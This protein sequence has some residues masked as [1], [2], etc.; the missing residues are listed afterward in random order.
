MVALASEYV[1]HAGWVLGRLEQ[2]EPSLVAVLEPGHP[3]RAQHH[4][5]LRGG[6]ARHHHLVQVVGL[7]Q[8]AAALARA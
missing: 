4:L 6:A 7:G 3:L 2:H 1:L 5:L 8:Q